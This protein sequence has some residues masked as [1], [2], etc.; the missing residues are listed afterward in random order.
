MTY[1]F[2]FEFMYMKNIV[3]S[4]L[5][6][7]V[8]RF[9]MEDREERQQRSQNVRM[10]CRRVR[11]RGR[12]RAGVAGGCVGPMPRRPR[13]AGKM[14]WRASSASPLAAEKRGG[15]GVREHAP[16]VSAGRTAPEVPADGWPGGHR[17]GTGIR[18][19]L[20]WKSAGCAA[21]ARRRRSGRTRCAGIP[22]P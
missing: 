15:R 21:A 20:A 7:C 8:P 5:K 12:C 13:A 11:R 10:L 3:K 17:A 4:Y 16:G 9:Q 2:I 18:S 19:P 14:A 22:T 1:E 6:S